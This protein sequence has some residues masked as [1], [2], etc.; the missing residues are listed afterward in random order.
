VSTA[1]PRLA[2]PAY[3]TIDGLTWLTY[4]DH[5]IRNAV[6]AVV[7]FPDWHAGGRRSVW[8]AE[9]SLAVLAGLRR[10]GWGNAMPAS[11]LLPDQRHTGL[12]MKVGS[13][14]VGGRLTC[15][16]L[17]TVETGVMLGITV[18][19]CIP[20]FAFDPECGVAGLA[21]CGWRGIASGIV[22][23]F[24]GLLRDAAGSLRAT[25]FLLGPAIGSCCYEVGADL[26][27]RFPEAEVGHYA[28]VTDG[29]TF[30][31]LKSL[32]VGR[33][34]DLGVAREKISVDITCTSCKNDVLSSYRASGTEGGRML[35]V[36]MLSR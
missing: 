35:A 22:E 5:I 20:L 2:E 11:I 16:G 21:H 15:D 30:F 18:A 7:V 25:G 29:R 13:A 4:G 3:S 8:K 32:V 6:H 9:A 23:H 28:R 14:P 33:L 26:L 1:V 12:A 36:V 10:I 19:D 17:I 31:D 34:G 27:S 24:A